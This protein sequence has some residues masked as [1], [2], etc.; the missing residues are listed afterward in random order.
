MARTDRNR[1]GEALD[2]LDA[3]PDD[4]QDGS[5]GFLL[6]TQTCSTY[7]TVAGRVYCTSPV[8]VDAADTEGATPSFTTTGDRIFAVNIGTG[9]PPAGTYVIGSSVGGRVC[10]SFN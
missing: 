6:I 9:I 3:L 7:P 2:D 8:V 1:Q 5:A 10:F 4:Q